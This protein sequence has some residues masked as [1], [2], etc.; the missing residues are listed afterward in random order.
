[1]AREQ[2][3][4][5]T[6]EDVLTALGTAT[7]RLRQN[8][9]QTVGSVN[10][11]DTPLARATTSTLDAL[12]AYSLALYEG[13]EVPR[14]EAIPYLK[15][16]IE[17]DPNFAMAQAQLS[18][19]YTNTGQSSLA[20]EYAI[21]AFQLRDRVSDRERF[22]ISWRYYRDAIQNWDKGLELARAWTAT[23]PR[24]GF[25]FNALG[26][27][28][29]RLGQF[30]AS[31][32]PLR[33]SLRLDPKFVPSYG[34]LAASLLAVNRAAE[35]RATLQDAADRKLD[36][37]GARRLSYLLGFVE[38]DR[39][40]MTRAFEAS[41]GVRENN[42]AYGWEAHT[43][44]FEGRLATAHE[45]FRRGIQ[46]SLQGHFNEVASQL[47]MEDAETHAIV[48]QCQE[49]RSELAAGLELNRDN[50]T[51]ER[52]SRI[53]ALCGA[54][55]EAL[56]LAGEAAKRFP[57]ATLTNQ[58][59]VPVISAMLAL[60]RR[61]PQRAIQILDPVRPYDHAPSGEFWPAY[62][63]G[64]AYLALKDG[65]SAAVQFRSILDRRGEV[66]ASMLYP[67]AHLGLARA[68]ILGGD[69]AVARQAYDNLF[70]LWNGADADLQP[71]K[72]ARLEY[73]RLD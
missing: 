49:A 68:A 4:A 14:L 12:H 72:D 11:Y 33:Q 24:E 19:V 43:A 41:I 71:L 37:A 62:L 28:L 7:T 50:A 5:G 70:T 42:S 47:T 22:S 35:A 39:A 34:N 23:Y 58:L 66:P 55:S 64:Q 44:A 20:P 3:E 53:S 10:L 65:A 56:S 27:A 52:A 32:E 61:E 38:G 36:F 69:P 16:A 6:K 67:L 31:I 21:K 40:T 29:I 57:E 48:G 2:A 18:A 54:A 51:I 73:M 15:R 1:M 9:A 46:L 60:G 59:A 8:L 63:R 17:I 25:A 30:E 45:Q 26:V 13:R